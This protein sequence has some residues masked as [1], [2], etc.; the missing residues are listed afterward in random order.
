[1]VKEIPLQLLIEQV[2][3]ETQTSGMCLEFMILS[4]FMT[5]TYIST[6]KVIQI[7]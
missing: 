2:F 6:G 7:S 4:L 1:M 3:T 5:G